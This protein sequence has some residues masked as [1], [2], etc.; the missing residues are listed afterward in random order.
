MIADIF[1]LFMAIVLQAVLSI[2]NMLYISFSSKNAP[3]GKSNYVRSMGI[4]IAIVLRVVLLF[5]FVFV[6]SKFTNPLFEISGNKIFTGNFTLH[7]LIEL[8]GGAFI[9]YTA[10][11]EIWH[12]LT[13][14]DFDSENTKNGTSLVKLFV[15]ITFMNLI[16]S[17]DSVLSVVA[18]TEK[19]WIMLLAVLIGGV[20]MIWLSN[21]ITA[22][23]QKNKK[24]EILGLFILLLVGFMLMTEAAHLSDIHVFGAE[25]HAL[26]SSTFYMILVILVVVDVLQSRYQKRITKI[27]KERKSKFKE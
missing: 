3:A 14:E 26:H 20:L 13:I 21:R 12:M 24:F 7:G 16:F 27:E 2:D 9:I 5:V 17:F 1:T 25:I 10:I 19:F 4:I 22:F 23:L 15:M 8:V 18:I 6:L 11:K